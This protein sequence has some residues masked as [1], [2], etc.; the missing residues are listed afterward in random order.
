[1]TQPMTKVLLALL[2]VAMTWFQP[3]T[4]M[5]AKAKETFSAACAFDGAPSISLQVERLVYLELSSRTPC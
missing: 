2:T 4:G 1:M 3:L 5:R